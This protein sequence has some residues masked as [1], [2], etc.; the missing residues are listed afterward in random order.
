M[1]GCFFLLREAE[2]S[3]LL[4]QNVKLDASTLQVTI[5]LPSSK[6]DPSAASVDRSWG[7]LCRSHGSNS[8]PSHLAVCQMKSLGR[9]CGFQG[10]DLHLPFFPDD[11][12]TTVDKLRVVDTREIPRVDWGTHFGRGRIQT[13]RWTLTSVGWF[14]FVGLLWFASVPNRTH[15]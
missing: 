2:A 3:L 14:P 1:I 4:A 9:R 10:E 8:C 7:C 12:G 5:R 11:R 6:T 13:P 15:G